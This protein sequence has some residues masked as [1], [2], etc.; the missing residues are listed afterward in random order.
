MESLSG[1]QLEFSQTPK[2]ISR[3]FSVLQPIP[4]HTVNGNWGCNSQVDIS[5]KKKADSP[6]RQGEGA[7]HGFTAAIHSVQP[8]VGVCSHLWPPVPQAH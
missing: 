4:E 3:Q 2:I 5:A 7:A 1:L 6:E 8:C